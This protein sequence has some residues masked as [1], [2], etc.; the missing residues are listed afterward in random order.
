MDSVKLIEKE[1]KMAKD[2]GWKGSLPLTIF[3]LA[4][5]ALYYGNAPVAGSFLGSIVVGT[6]WLLL[7]PLLSNVGVSKDVNAWFV[8]AAA[9]AYIAAAFIL[10]GGTFVDAG[11]WST[12]L[13]EVATILSWLMAGIGGLVALGTTR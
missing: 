1:E 5:A 3:L 9:F 12:W 4:V 13:I 10:V 8:R 6:V 11:N 7:I 2:M